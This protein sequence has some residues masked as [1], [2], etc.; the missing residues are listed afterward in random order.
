MASELVWRD[1]ASESCGLSLA[2]EIVSVLYLHHLI[3]LKP[4]EIFFV[5]DVH[6]IRYSV[7]HIKAKL[8]V[9]KIP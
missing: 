3:L 4:T 2:S 8:V 1:Q 9:L 6:G 7:R 5:T